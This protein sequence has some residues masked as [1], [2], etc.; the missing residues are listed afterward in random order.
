MWFKVDD[1]FPE[2]PKLE[3]LE[4]EPRLYM[5]AITVWTIMGAD[6]ARR[7]TDG[8]VSHARL[9]KVLFRI[10]KAARDGARAL[11][12]CGLWVEVEG[13]W[14]YHDWHDYQPTKSDVG[15]SRRT[16]AERQRRWRSKHVDASTDASTNAA[17]TTS[18]DAG[19]ASRTRSA[20]PDPTRPDPDP[21][22]V[23]Q[24]ESGVH[25]VPRPDDSLAR[26]RRYYSE[27]LED[28]STFPTWTAPAVANAKSLAVWADKHADPAL[29]LRA[30]FLGFR[31]DPWAKTKGYPIG[32]L[33]N[34][35][36]KYHAVGADLLEQTRDEVAQ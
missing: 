23:P 2:H 20:Y 6:C 26:A 34:G 27:L 25:E 16:K 18:R 36:Q 31:H 15:A 32:A 17:T 5:A 28:L 12:S 7:L 14:S 4:H 9:D 30:A 8:F 21:P 11:V 29:A 24:P 10:G 22:V 19:E 33:A 3:E 13:G 35:A 1:G